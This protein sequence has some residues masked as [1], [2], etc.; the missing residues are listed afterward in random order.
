MLSALE[1]TREFGFDLETTSLNPRAAEI[2]GIAI[3]HDPATAEYIPL[4]HR[5]DSSSQLPRAYVLNKLRPYLEDPAYRKIGQNLKF[6][7]SIL[8]EK[9][10]FLRGMIAD[11]MIAGYLVE[12]EG[13]NNLATL[14]QKYLDYQ[15]VSYDQVCGTGKDAITF[16]QVSIPLATRY[17]AEDA[18]V[19][20]QLWEKL[21]PLLEKSGEGM[22]DVFTRVDLPLVPVLGGIEMTGVCIDVPWLNQLSAVFQGQLSE[23]EKRV[24]AHATDDLNL[25]SPKQLAHLL[26][27][28][29][30][31]PAQ[32][33]TKT[34]FSTDARVLEIL[35]PLHEVPRL[36]L[37]YREI[38][39][40]KGTYVDPL[41]LAP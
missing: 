29:L 18:W 6:D 23:I 34:G 36:L 20:V 15:V 24:R 14:A 38:A 4:G 2:V 33:K 1:K 8:R 16:D 9:G 37:E 41:P 3:C 17:A 11:T 25:N 22:M 35:S 27:E 12:L 19:V 30:G 32:N 13:R 26:F 31:L 39:K 40:L 10:I 7:W 5:D 21:K 28:T